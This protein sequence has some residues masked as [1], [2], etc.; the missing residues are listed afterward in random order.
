MDITVNFE[1]INLWAIL[2]ATVAVFLL[3]GIWY[4]PSLFGRFG[5]V[6]AHRSDAESDRNI[7]AIFVLAFILQWLT[8]SLL[9]AVLGPNSTLLGGLTVGLLVGCFFVTTALGITD[10]FD[11][12]PLIH[13]LV[14]GGYHITSFAVMGMIIGFWH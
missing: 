10:I 13:L 8:A 9:A 14:N 5:V 7:Q 11:N 12:K 1:F 4:S 6:A 2:L 3:G